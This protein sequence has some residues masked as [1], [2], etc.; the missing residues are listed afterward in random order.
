MLLRFIWMLP[1]CWPKKGCE[2]EPGLIS[3]KISACIN[4]G[5]RWIDIH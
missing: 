2:G 1:T 5:C 4:T 3:C